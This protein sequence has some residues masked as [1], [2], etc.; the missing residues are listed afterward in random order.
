[1]VNYTTERDPD[2]IQR[3]GNLGHLRLRHIETNEIILIPT[4]SQDPKDPLTWSKAY[5]I[6]LALLVCLAMFFCNFLA[7][8]PTVAIVDITI[9]F[10]GVAPPMPGFPAAIAKISYLFTTTALLQG[11]GNL[12]WMP[13][14]IKYGRRPV[15]IISF[16]AY[17]ATAIWAGVSKSYASELAS[18]IL[19]GFFAGAG[20][21]VAPLT[22]SDIFFLHE[23]G[24]FMAMYTVALSAGVSGGI[25][26][27]GLVTITHSWR[28]IYYIA[29]ALIGALTIL[30]ILTLPETS[31]NRSTEAEN[32][33]AIETKVT[34][35]QQDIN[36]RNESQ[37]EEA[38]HKTTNHQ[39]TTSH[40]EKESY[41]RSL[42]LVA[43]TFTQESLWRIGY[44]PVVLLLLPPVLWATLVMS[45]T[46]GFLVAISANFASA[47]S[48]FYGFS[49]WQSGLAFVSG[50]I[51][52]LLGILGGGWFSDWL[53][54][55]F[56]RRNG[57]IREP[58]MR[59]PAITVAL[60]AG[61][62]GLVLYG[63]GIEY[64]WH[65]I[66]PTIALGLLSF[67]IA[68]GTN[69]SIVYIIDSYRPIAGE[70]V[71]T[72]LA[73]KSAFGFLLS[74]YTNPW[75]ELQGYARSFG[76]MA[77]ICG[78][79]LLMWV[80]LFFYGR[81]I[82]KS[83]LQWRMIQNLMQWDKDREVGE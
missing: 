80:P 32:A 44:R 53:A 72:Q 67:A 75:V 68:Q 13:L 71:V 20:E 31:F 27:A 77:G 9:D 73:F 23:R 33:T 15:Y 56:T 35:L 70:T 48:Q 1:M 74:F 37:V 66:V 10:T 29:T 21:C 81:R 49:S 64:H 41:I 43:G 60:I 17:T 69:V 57:G 79:V 38:E 82:R 28:Y 14:I 16:A 46:I 34:N 30:V 83:T 4:P 22:I 47:F 63:C 59:L 45:V 8:G 42:R 39:P 3:G 50:L 51:G 61:P 65:W 55:V 62:L 11:T 12:I 36:K 25:I 7:A 76:T 54:D 18:R 2:E 78:G 58:E 5:R 26:V 19:M 24:L 6:Y 52:T 40:A